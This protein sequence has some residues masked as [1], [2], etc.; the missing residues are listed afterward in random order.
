MVITIIKTTIVALI[1][2]IMKNNGDTTRGSK[3]D[4]N[5]LKLSSVSFICYI[6]ELA[7]SKIISAISISWICMKNSVRVD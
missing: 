5:D 6:K 3:I 2:I 7:S 4:K 1:K